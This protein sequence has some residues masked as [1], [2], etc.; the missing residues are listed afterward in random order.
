MID[1]SVIKQVMSED[2]PCDGCFH[3]D[4]CATRKEA[5]YAFVMYV[6]NGKIHPATPKKPTRR[7]FVRVMRYNYKSLVMKINREMKLKGLV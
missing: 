1:K 6:H 7:T 4:R 5:C 2:L 3:A